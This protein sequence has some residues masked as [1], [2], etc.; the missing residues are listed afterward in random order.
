M[1]LLKHTPFDLFLVTAIV[2]TFHHVS[3]KTTAL[4]FESL[5]VYLFTFHHVS[6][7]TVDICAIFPLK[8]IFTF[9]HVSIKTNSF[10]V[11][12]PLSF[13]F[14]FHHVSIKTLSVLLSLQ[15]VPHSHS[16]MY[17][18]KRIGAVICL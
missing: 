18:L 3:I 4:P 7:K 16:T 11:L 2:F 10:K 1:Y 13:K 5:P 14:T 8:L 15:P 12:N 6:I 17:L 9:H